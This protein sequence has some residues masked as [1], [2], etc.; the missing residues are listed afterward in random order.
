MKRYYP[1]T[2]IWLFALVFLT[3]SCEK[4]EPDFYDKNE[5]GVYFDY[6]AS[7]DFQRTIN[8][9]DHVLGNPQEVPLNLKVKLLGYLVEGDRKAVLKTKPVEGYPEATVTIPDVVFTSEEY[10]KEVEITIARPDERDTDYAICIYFDA[11]DSE[12][13][14]GHGITGKEE[15]VI[16]VKEAY[17][18]AWGEY[19]WFVSYIGPWSVDKHIF[20]INLLQDNDYASP[21]KLNDWYTLC[22]YNLQAVNALR[23][24][25]LDNPD[26]PITVDIPFSADNSYDKPAYWGALH[27]QYLGS[28]SSSLFANLAKAAGANTANETD[29]L[30]GDENT[31]KGLNRTAVGYM[32][33][34]YNMYFYSWGLSC[35]SYRSQTWIPMFEDIDYDVIQPYQWSN[36]Y[37]YG[38]GDMVS[39]YYGEY[40]AEKYKFMIKTWLEKQGTDNFV[41]VQMFPLI[42]DWSTYS[43]QWDSTIGGEDQIKTCYKA[44]KEAYDAAPAGTYNFTF[45]ELNLE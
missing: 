21:S 24:Q 6:N 16:Y 4:E 41:L 28:Y 1:Y 45:P 38:A 14:L 13:Q 11:E 19:D 20:F 15:F 2:M 37:V 30:S 22:N 5:N 8:F 36:N 42:L 12:S 18:P 25:R 9:A 39:K 44:F 17:T 3:T 32:M 40:S 31:V 34:Q 35:N 43:A 10:Q 29:V 7:A 23:Q 33:N 26:E 27:E